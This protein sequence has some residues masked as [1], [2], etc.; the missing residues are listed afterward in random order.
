MRMQNRKDW[1]IV[2]LLPLMFGLMLW[3]I[4]AI[5]QSDIR[6]L[7][8]K[9]VTANAR[10]I[11]RSKSRTGTSQTR[12]TVYELTVTFMDKS[13]V[14]EEAPVSEEPESKLKINVGEFRRAKITITKS[15]FDKINEQDTVT[16]V[17]LPESPT[18]GR[19]ADE[20]AN[21]R[22]TVILTL[23]GI[24]VVSAFV[25]FGIALF[26]RPTSGISEDTHE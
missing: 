23:I 18:K 10:V 24:T 17:Y 22:P 8:A 19:L 16:I 12:R 6:K 1:I 13:G 11:S 26:R 9:G 14:E 25:C 4:M 5:Q 20:V 3:G 21:W 7:R 15:S 2:G